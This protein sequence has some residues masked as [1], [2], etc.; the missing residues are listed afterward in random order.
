M[1]YLFALVA[2]AALVLSGCKPGAEP[3]SEYIGTWVQTT[4]KQVTVE[5]TRNGEGLLVR[6]TQPGTTRLSG[7]PAPPMV[8]TAPATIQNGTLVIQSALGNGAWAIDES[9]GRLVGGT[10]E[11]ERVN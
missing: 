9:T 3:G 1:K 7:G 5:I 4:D 11:Y 2:F 8:R 6:E 10:V